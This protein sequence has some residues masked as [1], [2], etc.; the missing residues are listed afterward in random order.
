L[1]GGP[2]SEG[3]RRPN[4]GKMP[5]T[6]SPRPAFKTMGARR[7]GG[8]K[9]GEVM[10]G[11]SGGRKGNP[12]LKGDS[13]PLVECGK[14]SA[15]KRHQDKKMAKPTF[16]SFN[17]ISTRDTKSNQKHTMESARNRYIRWRGGHQ[18]EKMGTDNPRRVCK[19]RGHIGKNGSQ[20]R[21]RG[22]MMSMGTEGPRIGPDP[23][24][25]VTR[26]KENTKRV[27]GEK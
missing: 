20:G 22:D 4:K 12:V 3:R 15:R 8:K 27:R 9:V 26:R 25:W 7:E 13:K 17:T 1:L 23:A 10:R 2:K 21:G 18:L 24:D 14:T 19:R 6:H 5:H 11:V 16:V